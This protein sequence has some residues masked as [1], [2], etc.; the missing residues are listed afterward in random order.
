M[1]ALDWRDEVVPSPFDAA[2]AVAVHLFQ[3]FEGVKT[4]L[5]EGE[6]LETGDGSSSRRRKERYSRGDF[7]SSISANHVHDG[8]V[9]SGMIRD[10]GIGLDN[11]L[12]E[13]ENL[14]SFCNQPLDLPPGHERICPLTLT[15]TLTMNMT[16]LS[17]HC[18]CCCSSPLFL[19][20][21]LF[22]LSFPIGL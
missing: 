21:F 17:P 5:S 11:I 9:T 22:F 8:L 1:A 14:P 18:R 10:P 20:L 13:D 7:V 19:F 6:M 16:L 15:L 12:V 3:C 4:G 2:D